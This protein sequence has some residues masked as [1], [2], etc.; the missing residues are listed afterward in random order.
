MDSSD[1]GAPFSIGPRNI[2]YR[3]IASVPQRSITSS[4]LTTLPRLFDIFSVTF[5]RGR[6]S[7]GWNG[8]SAS[9]RSATSAYCA[10]VDLACTTFALISTKLA[11]VAVGAAVADLNAVKAPPALP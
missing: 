5:S 9:K 10:D 11:S 1:Q 6:S 7:V 4:G 8:A 3:R 2:S